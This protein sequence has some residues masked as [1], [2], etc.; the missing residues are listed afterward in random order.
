VT[1]PV[2]DVPRAA[3]D[4]PGAAGN[5]PGAAGNVSGAAGGLVPR[6]A[7][8]PVPRRTGRWDRP[9][10]LLA[11]AGLLPLTAGLL[12]LWLR[13]G[14]GARCEQISV[15]AYF[16]PGATWTRA[17]DSQPAPAIMILDITSSGAGSAPDRAYAAAVARAQ[18]AGIKVLGYASTRY[19]RRPVAAVE[20]DVRHYRAWYHVT[21]IFLDEAATGTGEFSYDQKLTRYIRHTDPGPLVMLNPGTYPSRRYMALGDVVLAYEGSYARYTR[22][23]VPAWVD[24]YPA[25]RFSHVVYATPGARLDEA[26]RLAVARHAGYVYV[27]DMA[28]RNPY[29]S[30][31]RY[32]AAENAHAAGMCQ[33]QRPA[34]DAGLDGEPVPRGVGRGTGSH[35]YWQ[36]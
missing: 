10:L 22:L 8:R 34:T 16:Y 30:L 4:V 23:Q 5:V 12:V 13:P 11:L 20:A 17:I 2:G 33:G 27:T 29:R 26:L 7:G 14:P 32:W 25:A 28:G 1:G 36:G 6:R 19:A 3:G 31:P 35:A 24:S 15:P 18:G 9:R 21:G